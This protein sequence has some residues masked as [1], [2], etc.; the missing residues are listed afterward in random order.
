[1]TDSTKEIGMDTTPGHP[2][3]DPPPDLVRRPAGQLHDFPVAVRWEVTRRH[4]YYL[5]FWEEVGRYRR[6]RPDDPPERKLLGYAATLVLAAIGVSGEPVSPATPFPELIDAGGDPAFLG[7][8]VQPMTL[9]GVAAMMLAALPPA[10]RAFVGSLLLN[11]GMEEHHKG[12]DPATRSAESDVLARTP[13]P[14]LDSYP[15]AP[16]FYVHLGASQ[17]AIV[18]D[19]EDQVR[20][21]KARRGVESSK[22]H[23]AKLAEY[24]RVWD[25]REGW[26]GGGYDRALELPFAAVAGELKRPLATVVS[27][28][29]TAFEFVVG[30]PFTPELWWRVF[31][32]LKY[33]RLFGDAKTAHSAGVRRRLQS[34]VT[35]P[36]PDSVVSPVTDATRASTTVERGSAVGDNVAFADLLIDLRDLI[37]RGLTDEEVA[38]RLELADP[39][40]VADFRRHSE[41]L[42]AL[43]R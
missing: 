41:E 27:R 42:Q 14:A 39:E 40:V 35:R 15:D 31:G 34:P 17:R 22:V 37:A 19:T 21:W 9:R 3:S 28:Y 1:V 38:R 32:P 25:L 20:R 11:S 13:S 6:G 12:L 36:V 4:P 16:L 23:T 43:S 5:T 2:P 30:R 18:R 7:G 29:R 24:L 10:D 26:A 8:S 33:S